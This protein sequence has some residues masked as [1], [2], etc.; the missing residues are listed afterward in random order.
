MSIGNLSLT[1]TLNLENGFVT[2][3]PIS[4]KLDEY[5]HYFS[6]DQNEYIGMEERDIKFVGVGQL[7][8]SVS[9]EVQDI[10]FSGPVDQFRITTKLVEY[11][12]KNTGFS[13]KEFRYGDLTFMADPS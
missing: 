6:F 4:G 3:E 11:F 1:E 5:N 2:F 8:D 10:E 13:N 9:G 7:V 12:I